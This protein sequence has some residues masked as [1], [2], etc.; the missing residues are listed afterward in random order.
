[1]NELTE[2]RRAASARSSVSIENRERITL[3]GI[4]RVD[5][6][7]EGEVCAR[8]ESSGVAVYG[9]NLHISRLDLDNGVMVVDGFIN[10]VEYSDTENKGGIFSRLFK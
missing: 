3:S 2:V 6:F 7:D 5:S 4:I 9:Q 8:C 10:G 1:M